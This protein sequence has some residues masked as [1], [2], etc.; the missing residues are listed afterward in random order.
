MIRDIAVWS[1]RSIVAFLL[2][3]IL[4]VAL[5]RF[6]PPAV[7]PLMIKRVVLA[8]FTGHRATIIHRWTSYE[9][10]SPAVF[11]ALI[12]GEDGKFMRHD[13]IDWKA[14]ERAQRANPGRIKRGKLPLGAS[15]ITMQTAK[16][17]FLIDVRSMVRKGFEVYF[18]YLIEALWGKQRILEVYANMIEWGDGVYGVEAASRLYFGGTRAEQLSMEQAARLAA[19]VPNPRR[20]SVVA[21]SP[22]TK[23]RTAFIR[24]RMGGIAI[25][26]AGQERSRQESNRKRTKQRPSTER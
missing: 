9:S 12:A 21:P 3:S 7:T 16:N 2:G 11:R 5:F 13:G 22:Y 10:I 18:V 25:P 23:K 14:V 19:V 1:W 20:F 26:R 15:T 24:G 8:P 6:V 17:V 4:V